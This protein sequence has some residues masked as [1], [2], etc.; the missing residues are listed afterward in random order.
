MTNKNTNV[1]EVVPGFDI[2]EE[3]EIEEKENDEIYSIKS[4]VK[5]GKFNLCYSGMRKKTNKEICMKPLSVNGHLMIREI[6]GFFKSEPEKCKVFLPIIDVVVADSIRTN[7]AV[8]DGTFTNLAEAFNIESKRV[9]DL[10]HTFLKHSLRAIK[11]LQKN[12]FIHGNLCL[13]SFWVKFDLEKEAACCFHNK[14]IG[15]I[16]LAD[17]EYCI[18]IKD[19]EDN[20][21]IKK[22]SEQRMVSKPKSYKYCALGLHKGEKMCMKFD[23]ESIFYILVQLY[24][25]KLPWDKFSDDE[26]L[27]RKEKEKMRSPT[28][29]FYRDIPEHLAEIICFIDKKSPD[30]VPDTDDIKKRFYH[31]LKK[32]TFYF[33]ENYTL[34]DSDYTRTADYYRSIRKDKEENNEPFNHAIYEEIIGKKKKKV[35]ASTNK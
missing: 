15:E 31:Y 30:K 23:F 1:N 24:E 22:I 16:L 5:V 10:Q 25:N 19:N 11:F 8:L 4:I 6:M 17:L 13:T 29:D 20:L 27:I 35:K 32:K 21:K 33:E 34:G 7:F 18:K 26:T 2:N 9:Y 12:D 3:C 28:Y 14:Y